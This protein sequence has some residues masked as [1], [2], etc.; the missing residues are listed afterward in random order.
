MHSSI[1]DCP[2]SVVDYVAPLVDVFQME[3]ERGIAESLD[4]MENETLG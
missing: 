3:V 2:V 1:T 4:V